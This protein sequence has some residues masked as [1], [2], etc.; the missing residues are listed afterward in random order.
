MTFSA[1]GDMAGQYNLGSIDDD[2]KPDKVCILAKYAKHVDYG[3]LDQSLN[4]HTPLDGQ[5]H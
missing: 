5:V 1:A 4:H 3:V 2:G